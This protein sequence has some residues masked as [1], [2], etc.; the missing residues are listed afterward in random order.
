MPFSTADHKWMAR[1]HQ[2]AAKGLYSTHPNPRVG[3]VI[4]KND[5]IVGEGFHLQSGTPHAEIH[6]LNAAGAAAEGA[7]AYVTLEPCSHTGKTP[8]CADALIKA[9]VARVVAAIED[10]NPLVS[11]QG[12][13]RLQAAGIVVES[14]LQ[15]Q[16]TRQL[17]R[18]F[19]QRMQTGLPWV[20]VKLA[21]SLDGRTAM[22]SGESQWITGE[23]ARLDVQRLRAQSSAV[24]TGIG[25]VL[26][27]DPSM[28]VRVDAAFLGSEVDPQQ[29]LRVIVDSNLRTPVDGKILNGCDKVL[30]FH[31]SDVR[32]Q[33]KPWP[34]NVELCAIGQRHNGLDLQA[35]LSELGN[36]EINEVHVE[37]GATLCGSLLASGL[38]D[39]LIIYMASHLMGDTG[40]GLFHLPALTKMQ[41]R[42]SLNIEDIRPLGDDWKITAT[43][44]K[45]SI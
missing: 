19:I 32:N 31:R 41:D 23:A 15:A 24:L 17:N 21:M 5:E 26:D 18:G 7:T 20:S 25:T 6:A 28:N 38:V 43:P 29:P 34:D 16:E 36:R 3:C 35:V 22:A 40:R 37:A 44:K 42:I 8:P 2:L 12:L 13:A 39:K 4:V 10:P 27:D 9:G 33:G 14:G 11:G 1:A 45:I 30:I